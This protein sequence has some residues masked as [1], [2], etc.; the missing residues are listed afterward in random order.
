VHGDDLRFVHPLFAAGVRNRAAPAQLRALHR[1]LADTSGDVE[2][3]ARHAALGGDGPH[4]G[5]ADALERAGAVADARGAPEAAAELYELAAQF[6]PPTEAADR[7][8]RIRLTAE[9]LIASGRLDPA[10][11]LLESI[12]DAAVGLERADVLLLSAHTSMDNVEAARLSA[13]AAAAAVGDPVRAGHAYAYLGDAQLVNNDLGAAE[14]TFRTA[15]RHAE[16]GGDQ[17]L[18]ARV[19]TLLTA[20]QDWTGR[21]DSALL[22]R[23][24]AAPVIVDSR[25]LTDSPAWL[26]GLTCMLQDR[27]DEAR[28][29]WLRLLAAIDAMGDEESRGNMLGE[30]T[31]LECRAGD[32]A[33]AQRYAEQCWQAAEHLGIDDAVGGARCAMGW[34]HAYLGDLD[35]AR[36]PAEAGRRMSTNAGNTLMAMANTAVLGLIAVSRGDHAEAVRVLTPIVQWQAEGGWR[37]PTIPPFWANLI[38]AEIATGLL[39][40]AEQHLDSY[41]QRA[42]QFQRPHGLATA[43]RCRAI[44]HAAHGDLPAALATFEQAVAAHQH[45]YGPFELGRTL[46]AQGTVQRRSKHRRD[47]RTTLDQA[48]AIFERLGARAWIER[49]REELHRIGGRTPAGDALTATERAIAE[50]VAAGRTNRQVAAALSVTVHTVEANLTRI[51]R[52]LDVRSRTE[53]AAHLGAPAHTDDH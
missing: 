32:F 45:M 23:L 3:Q 26:L 39:E 51:Y 16:R 47:A 28:D 11:A 44:L 17:H 49:T 12:T 24:E 53:L 35:Q 7:R 42:D 25:P 31:Q 48:L 34:V 43:A 50:L 37:E 14:A 21:H 20:L 1:R 29:H 9:Q 8:R 2:D 52:K 22:K 4:E 13:L 27:M 33:Q 36:S 46:L 10:R 30:L 6:T 38:E 40:Q 15:L 19:L 5:T 18:V 41:Q